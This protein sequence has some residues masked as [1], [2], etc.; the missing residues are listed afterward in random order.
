MSNKLEKVSGSWDR[1]DA[2]NVG[3]GNFVLRTRI[4]AVMEA[5]SLPMKRLRERSVERN[6]LV[7]ATAGRK[8]RSIIVT[9]SNHIIL[10]AL[11]P[12]TVQE[13][14]NHTASKPWTTPA[15]QELKGGEFVS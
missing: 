3:H 15:L 4:I 12:Q 1:M 11:S 5:G 2:V 14:M 9:D 7:D 6:L 8:T 13:R 10:S